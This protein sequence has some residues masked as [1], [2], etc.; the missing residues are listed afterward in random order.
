MAESFEAKSV[1]WYPG[2]MAKTKRQM[3]ESIRLVDAV[4]EV[5]DAR[6][7]ASSKNPYLN[8][9]WQKRPR[10]LV[11][12]KAD[13]ADPR[14]TAQWKNYYESLG[15]GVVTA[16]S[17]HGRASKEI[18]QKVLEVCREK[19]ERD[20]AKG[21]T[22]P[23]RMMVSGIPNTGKSTLI[24]QLTGRAGGAKTGDKPGVTK[25]QQW[26]KVTTGGG[27][28][29]EMLDTPG[30]L[31]PKFDD[32]A[33]GEKIALIGSI[34]EEILNEYALACSLLERLKA[35]YPEELSARYKLSAEEMDVPGDFLIETVGKKRGHL[36]SGGL[37]DVERTAKILL[38]E[39]RGGK[40][41]RV[42]LESPDELAAEPKE[43]GRAED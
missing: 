32:P 5:V 7:P 2:H 10:V 35:R 30:I 16:D 22:R 40:I 43:A 21:M 28:T 4:V 38:D 12:N 13:L 33:V 19:I 27:V 8:Q 20:K 29:L 3:E 34:N 26:L 6:I 23:V 18:T 1:N 31:W 11:L 25:S 36:R 15:Y 41:G 24:N 9:L 37:V 17:L 39:F 14:V 42:S